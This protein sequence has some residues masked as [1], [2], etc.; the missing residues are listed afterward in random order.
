[1]K[2]LVLGVL[3][4][5]MAACAGP[6]DAETGMGVI[7]THAVMVRTSEGKLLKCESNGGFHSLVILDCKEVER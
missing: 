5:F 4:L 1:M 7:K 3:L 2:R 6:V